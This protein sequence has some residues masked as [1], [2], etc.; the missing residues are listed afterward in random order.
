MPKNIKI[1]SIYPNINSAVFQQKIIK[2]NPP[3]FGTDNRESINFDLK[4]NLDTLRK[5]IN[6]WG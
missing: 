4:T 2:V 6:G 5:Q 1:L 3:L